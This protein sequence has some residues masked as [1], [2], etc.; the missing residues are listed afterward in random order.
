MT[1]TIRAATPWT[2]DAL[3]QFTDTDP[4]WLA[5]IESDIPTGHSI[6]LSCGSSPRPL[7]AI[8][9]DAQGEVARV[10]PAYHSVGAAADAVLRVARDEVA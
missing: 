2:R 9:R 5:R 8:L 10:E 3:R 4:A 6:L 1:G 7:G